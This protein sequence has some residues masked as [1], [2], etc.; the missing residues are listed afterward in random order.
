LCLYAHA[1]AE[2]RARSKAD[3]PAPAVVGRAGP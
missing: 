1:F 2:R 3:V